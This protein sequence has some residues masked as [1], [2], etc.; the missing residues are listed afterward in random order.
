MQILETSLIKKKFNNNEK[1][2]L[3]MKLI[4]K[5]KITKNALKDIVDI[6]TILFTKT[7]CRGSCICETK[8]N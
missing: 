8:Y 5:T 2:P 7:K 3:E 6:I 4:N 1:N